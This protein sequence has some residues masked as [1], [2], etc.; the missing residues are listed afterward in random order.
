MQQS[1]LSF[2]EYINTCTQQLKHLSDHRTEL[3]YESSQLKSKILEI[4]QKIGKI[5][6][7]VTWFETSIQQLRDSELI[8]T[9]EKYLVS[10]SVL[11]D[12]ELDF[13]NE[14][15]KLLAESMVEV[16]LT[17]EQSK[18][19]LAELEQSIIKANRS[20]DINMLMNDIDQ[21]NDEI[22]NL[23]SN[24]LQPFQTK[25]QLLQMDLFDKPQDTLELSLNHLRSQVHDTIKTCNTKNS[26]FDLLANQLNDILPFFRFLEASNALTAVKNSLDQYLA[27][28]IKLKEEFDQVEK[29]LKNRIDNFFYI[30][31][32]NKIYSKIDPH[33]S[34]KT[35]SFV[36]LFPENEKPRLEIYLHEDGDRIICPT[37]YFSAAQLNILSLSIFLARA[38]HVE[39]EG[40][41]VET[42]LI[43]DPIHSM[44]SINILSTIDLL[45]NISTR[46][47]RQ[48]ILSTHDENFYELLKVKLPS[49]NYR[50][51]FMRLKSYGIVLN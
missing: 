51:K 40:R 48:I 11:P 30:E 19:N 4:T 50:S 35:I 39:H 44:D 36:C 12:T 25:L 43:D 18:K 10:N 1:H 14:R 47:G 38:L 7:E 6:S 32:I 45:R 31:L 21:S 26:L 42:I 2:T 8:L 24:S 46:F 13:F 16:T 20:I 9:I 15:T 3:E 28:E 22:L 17:L 41:P 29:R 37:F 34:F 5:S 27:L 33:P 23:L 49:K